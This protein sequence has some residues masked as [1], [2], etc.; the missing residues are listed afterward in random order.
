MIQTELDRS[1]ITDPDHPK[2][3]HPYIRPF[4]PFIKTD[5]FSTHF[6][7]SLSKYTVEFITCSIIFIFPHFSSKYQFSLT[8]HNPDFSQTLKSFDHFL[9]CGNPALVNIDMSSVQCLPT[10]SFTLTVPKSIGVFITL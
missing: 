8:Q 4:H 3:T 2:G 7:P 5:R 10:S 9:T 1:W 6:P